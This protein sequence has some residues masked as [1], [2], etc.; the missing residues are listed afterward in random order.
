MSSS[1]LRCA[2][3][4]ERLE[5]G[6][7]SS[8]VAARAWSPAWRASRGARVAARVGHASSRSIRTDLLAG[9][10]I[11]SDADA[12]QPARARHEWGGGGERA[13]H[14]APDEVDPG[15]TPAP[16]CDRPS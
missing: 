2:N 7:R 15:T 3:A 6:C 9:W 5:P 13:E 11:G 1:F 16:A 4:G 8:L 14:A 12:A 10:T